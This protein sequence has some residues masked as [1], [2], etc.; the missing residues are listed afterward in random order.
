MS[1]SS[2]RDGSSEGQARG[3]FAAARA[4]LS[5]NPAAPSLHVHDAAFNAEPFVYPTVDEIAPKPVAPA[6]DAA[7]GMPELR[8]RIE[9]EAFRRG[10]MEAEARA[11]AEVA[12]ALMQERA[13][14]SMVVGAFDRARASYF[15][16]IEGEVVR[17]ALA[18]ARRI[19]HREAQLDPIL[20]RGAVRVALDRLEGS[21]QVNLRVHPSQAELWNEAFQGIERGMPR[22]VEDAS[23][24]P[25]ECQLETDLGNASFNI[26]QQM[27]EID[28]GFYD[29]LEERTRAGGDGADEE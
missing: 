9:T 4:R 3:S 22:I 17:L 8:E 26:E 16:R 2:S 28:Q 23:I 12:Q 19:L 1:S 21:T 14:I 7:V 5:P 29:L 10:K 6:G 15:M 25:G 11:Q 13:S 18:V 20:L 24:K 27:K